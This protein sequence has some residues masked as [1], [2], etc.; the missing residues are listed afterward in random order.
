[1]TVA[2]ARLDELAIT[3]IR[4]L[5][6]DG[7]QK[8]NSGHPGAP[9]GMAP[10]AHVLWMHFLRHAPRDPK[11]PNRDRFV[12]SAGHASMLLYSLLHLTGYDVGLDDLRSFRQWGSRTPGHP[13]YGLT[14]GVEATTGPLGQGFANGIGMAIAERRL[15]NE[16][17][18]I[19]HD[20]VDHRVFGIVSD[21]DLQE[22]VAAEAASLA[23]HLR[24]GRLVYLYDD[25][26]VQLD[27][28]TG[29]AWSENV[30]ERFDAYE[31][32][33]QRVQD[34]NDLEAIH[35][36]IASAIGDP[37]PSLIAVRTHIGFGSP[38]KQ[39]SQ[40]AHGSPLGPEEVRLTKL[41]YGWDPDRTFY[42]P[43]E[44]RTAMGASADRG[45]RLVADWNAALERY[46]DE[47]PS[48]AHELERRLARK[49]RRG[50]AN[51]LVAYEPGAALSTRKA[52]RDAIGALADPVPE[53]FGGSA[54]LSESTY[55]DVRDGGDF[56]ADEPGRNLRFGVREHA[57]G[58]VANGIAYHGGFIPYAG[59]F[60]NFSDYMRGSVRLAAMSGLQVV[61]VWTHDSIGLGED[62][63]THQPIEHYAALRAIPNLW[64]VRPADG[65]ETLAAWRLGM[66]RQDGP[67]A[68]SLS[69]QDLP[70]LEGT[71][72][73]AMAGVGRGGYVL[74]EAGGG[75]GWTEA[76]AKPARPQLILIGTGSELQLAVGAAQG[77]AAEGIATRV[78]SLPCWELFESQDQ[79]YRDAV[80]PPDVRKR[81]SVE[82]GA[83]LGWDRWTGPEGAIVGIDHYGA[84]APA[85]VIFEKFGFTVERVT[86]IA[87]R[88]VQEGLHG[89]ISTLEPGHLPAAVHEPAAG[90]AGH[91]PA[92]GDPHGR[93]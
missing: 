12:L 53:L 16:F 81:V 2:P 20:I 41:A 32:H 71:A 92:A 52:S 51:T 22:G 21:G 68:L 62:G 34:G 59:T 47:H 27:G 39:D 40:K 83:S 78:V 66:E 18:R 17:N 14:P 67:V 48:L 46:R 63:P 64:F 57:M 44:V 90:A 24:L 70:I 13:E 8:A 80:L 56:T 58:G 60:L 84:S 79:A 77:L 61:Y 55:T 30:L 93:H 23:G 69:R 19:G 25:N 74:R 91:L 5:A 72:E 33:T 36:A 45:D 28:P 1:M 86:D 54:D 89:P 29:M 37:R 73:L 42:V 43:D 75:P 50:W 26:H 76:P 85:S 88:V 9:M 11:W 82:A 15:A 7:V 65:N 49:L 3:T 10:M 31:W 35:A 87:R 38:N 6:I 4:T